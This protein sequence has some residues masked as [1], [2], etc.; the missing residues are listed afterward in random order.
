MKN[1]GTYTVP[2]ET[3]DAGFIP[4]DIRIADKLKRESKKERKKIKKK[5]EKEVVKTLKKLLKSEKKWKKGKKSKKAKKKQNDPKSQHRSAEKPFADM[6]LEKSFDVLL[7]TGGYI[8]KRYADN[9]FSP[10]D[11]GPKNK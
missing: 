6:F 11:Y 1:A 9:K 2:T 7:E 3:T 8:L 5:M 4:S 10:N